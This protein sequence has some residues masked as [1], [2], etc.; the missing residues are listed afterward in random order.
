MKLKVMVKLCLAE[1]DPKEMALGLNW[2][3]TN[4]VFG[5]KTMFSLVERSDDDFEPVCLNNSCDPRVAISGYGLIDL[6]AFYRPNAVS[7]THLTLPTKA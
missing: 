5:L 1:V 7:Y 3:S 2:N 4:E 6:F